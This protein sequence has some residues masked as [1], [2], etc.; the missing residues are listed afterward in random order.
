MKDDPAFPGIKYERPG[1]GHGASIMTI[2]GGLTKR[3]Y[4][5]AMAM[6]GIMS[7]GAYDQVIGTTCFIPE[8]L[9]ASK[10]VIYADALIAEL[11][12]TE[13]GSGHV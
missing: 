4:I 5:A 12:K 7:S 3:E 2:V 9:A 6:Q 1:E 13:S 11:G 8:E 10:S